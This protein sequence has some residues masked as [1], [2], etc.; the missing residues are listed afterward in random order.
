MKL[1]RYT[2]PVA[3]M[4]S[5]GAFAQPPTGDQGDGLEMETTFVGDE[6]H[7]VKDANK[8][9]SIPELKL[10]VVDIP[11]ITYNLIPNKLNVQIEPKLIQAARVNVEEPLTKLYRGYVRG[12]FGLYTTTLGELYYMDGRS[13]NGTFS[14]HAKHLG[15]TGGVSS[16]DSIP[17]NFSRNEVH[18]W[19]KRFVKK[20]TLEGGFDW[21]KDVMHF[22]GFD[23]ELF[24]GVDYTQLQQSF[25][26]IDGYLQLKSYY[27]DTAKVN[28]HGRVKFYNYRD[29]FSGN[30]NNIDVAAHVRQYKGSELFSIDFDVNYNQF[31]FG[32][33]DG[34]ERLDQFTNTIVTA[35]PTASTFHDKWKI[36]AGASIVYNSK[37]SPNREGP[38]HFYPKVEANYSLLNNL[39][40][41]Y[42]G[43]DGNLKRT[44]YKSLTQ[45]NPFVITDP[46]L[47]AINTK[48]NA[49]GGIRGTISSQAS[50][51]AKLAWTNYE[52]FMYFVNDSIASP[53]NQFQII[54][55]GLKMT[56][57]TGE[58]SVSVTDEFKLF[59]RGDYFIYSLGS[60]KQ[61]WNQPTTRASIAASYNLANKF[62]VN[63]EAYTVGKRAAKSLVPVQGVDANKDGSYT[64]DL[65]G[66]ADLNLSIEYR[67]T[68]R[69]SAFVK[70]NNM[71]A[72]RYEVW[73][74]YNVQRFN[75][76]MGASYSF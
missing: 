48:L 55:D 13:R 5:L 25:N 76:L 3:L 66:Y 71:F 65:N 21:E 4:I 54:Y 42:V 59:G 68:K 17:D 36:L 20:H 9:S 15:S 47:R 27:R 75:A 63:A 11:P 44:T 51:N 56:N 37:F 61:A 16:N 23:S 8:E 69:L 14:I 34:S 41:P 6:A 57:L 31:Q 40:I 10:N 64:V 39:F 67:Y 43:I 74:N 62:M 70:F 38:F 60:E 18:L 45:T 12:G 50:F 2:L 30:E 73:N 22:Y 53:G 29:N 58:V 49:Y 24:T 52:D 33:R 7:M 46:E 32:L 1:T 35:T 26:N 72:A 28:Y 19:G